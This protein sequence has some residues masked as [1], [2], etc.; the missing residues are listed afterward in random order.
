MKLYEL[1]AAISF[2]PTP[3]IEEE[4]GQMIRLFR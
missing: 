1:L 3:F 2:H 4:I